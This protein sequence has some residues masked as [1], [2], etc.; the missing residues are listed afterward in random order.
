MSTRSDR[1]RY[2]DKDKEEYK[3]RKNEQSQDQ[4]ERP[5]R[6]ATALRVIQNVGDTHTSTIIPVWVSS[7]SV[8]SRE[9]LVY[10]LLDTQSDTTFILDETA[11]ALNARSEPVQLNLS[12]LASRNTIVSCR[13]LAGLQVR[14][15]YSDKIITL[16]VTYSRVYPCKQRPYSHTRYGEGMASS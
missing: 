9:V 16:P 15:F 14:G 5:S 2:S 4:S 13:K 12:T 11:K 3:E 8:P 7:T 1:A 6:E 10:A